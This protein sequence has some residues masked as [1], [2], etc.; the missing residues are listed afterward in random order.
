MIF[1]KKKK[2]RKSKNKRLPISNSIFFHLK[3]T[4]ILKVRNKSKSKN[5]VQIQTESQSE[6]R[7]NILMKKNNLIS[8]IQTLSIVT[9]TEKKIMKTSFKLHFLGV[10]E[11]DARLSKI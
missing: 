3:F 2:K 11:I 8:K 7:K 5:R 10:E 4:L 9:H 1:S 6:K